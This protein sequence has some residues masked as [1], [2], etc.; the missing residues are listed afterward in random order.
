MYPMQLGD[1]PKTY[2][3]INELK[4]D[5]DYEPKTNIKVG[6]KSFINWF[7]NYSKK[8]YEKKYY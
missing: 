1:V 6:I 4:S 2:A 5:F 8:K 3:D 7:C